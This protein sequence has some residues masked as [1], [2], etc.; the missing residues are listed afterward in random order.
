MSGVC[1]GCCSGVTF[2]HRGQSVV[3]FGCHPGQQ[4]QNGSPYCRDSLCMYV[5]HG[6]EALCS[7]LFLSLSWY[8]G[9]VVVQ[10]SDRTDRYM[11]SVVSVTVYLYHI[12]SR[13]A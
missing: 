13:V 1:G 5:S 2:N 10:A 8:E 11:L 3:C 6:R 12:N 7:T 9:T 4:T